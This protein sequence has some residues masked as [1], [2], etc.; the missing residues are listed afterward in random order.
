MTELSKIS[1]AL[2]CSL[3]SIL[4][5][6]SC[7]FAEEVENKVQFLRIGPFCRSKRLAQVQWGGAED[8]FCC[9]MGIEKRV[10]IEIEPVLSDREP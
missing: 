6:F 7:I 9:T 3:A 5:R 8:L 1:T 2:M 4:G 10:S